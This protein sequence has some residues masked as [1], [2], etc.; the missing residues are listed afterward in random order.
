[1]PSVALKHQLQNIKLYHSNVPFYPG[2][3]SFSTHSLWSKDKLQ[4]TA[5]LS[6]ADREIFYRKTYSL[7]GANPSKLRHSLL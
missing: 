6:N 4:S 7:A 3:I 5:T 1:M 2:H